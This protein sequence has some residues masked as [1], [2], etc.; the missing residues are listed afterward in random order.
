MGDPPIDSSGE[1]RTHNGQSSEGSA[2]NP[3]QP[4]ADLLVA[5]EYAQSAPPG[6]ANAETRSELPTMLKALEG[7]LELH[8]PVRIPKRARRRIAKVHILLLNDLMNAMD[9]V[10]GQPSLRATEIAMLLNSAFAAI[11]WCD[12]NTDDSKQ[13][14]KEAMQWKC[15][16]RRLQ[17]AEAGRWGAP[18]QRA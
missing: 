7:V 6:K 11:L 2:N 14:T 12:W 9:V 13:P 17:L 4:S 1:R 15:I 10:D 16:R 18:H 8:T 3:E 5:E